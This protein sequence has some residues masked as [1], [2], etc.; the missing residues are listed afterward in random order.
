MTTEDI[1]VNDERK[2]LDQGSG[3]INFRVFCTKHISNFII[4]KTFV[5]N[6]NKFNLQQASRSGVEL[7]RQFFQL[8]VCKFVYFWMKLT[9]KMTPRSAVN[10]RYLL[11]SLIL[12]KICDKAPK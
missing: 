11:Q 12:E 5:I 6:I 8:S 1:V 10:N 4:I 2:N 7:L 3:V 9:W